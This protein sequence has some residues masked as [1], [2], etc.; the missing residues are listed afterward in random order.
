MKQKGLKNNLQAEHVQIATQVKDIA[1]YQGNKV[2]RKES[3]DNS[4]WFSWD[5]TVAKPKGQ[6]P[7]SNAQHVLPHKSKNFC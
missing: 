5:T 6:I 7:T 2:N 1:E 4:T 3:R